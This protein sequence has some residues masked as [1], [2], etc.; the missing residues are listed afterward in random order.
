MDFWLFVGAVNGFLA[1]AAG[2]FGAHG[3]EGSVDARSLDI[4]NT[5][6]HYH[7]IHALATVVVTLAS[8]GG[9]TAGRANIA[10]GLFTAGVVL[11]SGSLYFLVLTRSNALVLLTPLGGVC[12]LAGWAMLAAAALKICD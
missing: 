7:L 9:V 11:F 2:A 5:A 8:R 10:A 6:A 4:D 3:L 12:F 1:V